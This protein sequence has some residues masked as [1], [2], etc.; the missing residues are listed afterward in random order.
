MSYY[1]INCMGFEYRGTWVQN[2]IGQ[3]KE[4]LHEI[5]WPDGRI[6]PFPFDN[7]LFPSQIDIER[8]IE[9]LQE[10]RI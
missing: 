6:T 1:S 8:F 10:D 2:E 9:N 4:I 5:V 3:D 7:T